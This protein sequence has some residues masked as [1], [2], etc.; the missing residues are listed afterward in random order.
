VPGCRSHEK[1]RDLHARLDELSAE[2]RD[3]AARRERLELPSLD[4]EM[5]SGLVDVFEETME[6]GT[7][8]KRSTFSA[9]W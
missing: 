7:N 2:E 6:K 8:Q 1:I 9:K 3:L 4:R 5:L